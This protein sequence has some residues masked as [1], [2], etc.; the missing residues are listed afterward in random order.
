[1]KI[2]TSGVSA[3]EIKTSALVLPVSEDNWKKEIV[4]IDGLFDKKLSTAGIED[5]FK[6]T[7]GSM[8]MLRTFEKN[9]AKVI[10]LGLGKKDKITTTQIRKA[11]AGLANYIKNSKIATVAIQTD[12]QALTELDKFDLG[13]VMTEGIMLGSYTYDKYK[14]KKEIRVI[15]EYTFI[16]SKAEIEIEKGIAEGMVF[17]E[18][19]ILARDLINESPTITTPTYLAKEAL[20]LAG[21]GITVE[22]LEKKDVEKLGMGAYLAVTRGSDEP[23]KF[24]KL[25]YKNGGPPGG[26]ASKKVVIAGK[27]ITFD[28]GGLSLKDAKNMEAMKLDMSGAAAV[29]GV[30]S[31]LEK[32]KPKVTVIGLIAACENMPGAKAIKPGDVVRAMNG[33]TIE[34]LNT[35]AEGRLTLADVL[36]YA[37]KE[38]PDYMIDLATL[39]GACMVAL[40]DEIAGLFSNNA[41]FTKQITTAAKAEGEKVWELPLEEDYKPLIKSHIADIENI[42]KTRYGGAITA[43]LF[44]EEFVDGK[45]WIHLDI[46]GPAFAE[47]D[48]PLTPKGGVGFGVRMLLEWLKGF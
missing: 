17:A 29:L 6:P 3:E 16:T 41:D 35:D 2:T 9:P 4:E 25:E 27:G 45:P 28:T 34:I 44:L 47:K 39:T 32:L 37:V 10:L 40:G 42:G 23:P 22:I 30:F 20:K 43:A 8:L 38:K 18:A 36:S 5:D 26:E 48:A 33:K 19:T 46:A 31:V 11:L 24:I 15:S 14:S 7:V 12:T 1:M 21:N 13:K